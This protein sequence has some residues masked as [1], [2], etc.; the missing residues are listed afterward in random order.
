V[1]TL[2]PRTRFRLATRPV[3][4]DRSGTKNMWVSRVGFAA[5]AASVL[6]RHV[7][8]ST[9][10]LNMRPATRGEQDRDDMGVDHMTLATIL[11]SRRYDVRHSRCVQ[12]LAGSAIRGV[13]IRPG[14][15]TRIGSRPHRSCCAPPSGPRRLPPPRSR[16]MN[17]APLMSNMGLPR[18]RVR[19]HF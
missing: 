14:E 8:G 4:P 7:G 6:A 16:V 19:P 11:D 17:L 2:P 5:L 3:P 10:S 1:W 15:K 13:R 12:A 18:H 9:E